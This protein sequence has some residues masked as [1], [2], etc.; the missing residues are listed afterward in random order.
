MLFRKRRLPVLYTGSATVILVS[1][2]M[3]LFLFTVMTKD[4]LICAFFAVPS[5]YSRCKVPSFSEIRPPASNIYSHFPPLF[6]TSNFPLPT[7][8]PGIFLERPLLQGR[9][10]RHGY[11][12]PTPHKACLRKGSPPPMGPGDRTRNHQQPQHRHRFRKPV[13]LRHP[14]PKHAHSPYCG[15]KPQQTLHWF[16]PER[17][18]DTPTAAPKCVQGTD[19]PAHR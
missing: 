14:F 6:L 13:S 11:Y 17:A 2:G 19:R 9:S 5:T 3:A 4:S 12:C 7:S 10:Y 8:Q 18:G 1:V 16:L 15:L